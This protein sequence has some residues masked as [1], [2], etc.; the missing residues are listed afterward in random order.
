MLQRAPQKN[1]I[2]QQVP[3][4]I[5]RTVVQVC[6][7][8][9][10][11]AGLSTKPLRGAE[12]RRVAIPGSLTL[13]WRLGR[14]VA[15]AHQ[16]KSDPVQAVAQAGQGALLFSGAVLSGG[17]CGWMYDRCRP[18]RRLSLK[19]IHADRA[20]QSYC[21]LRCWPRAEEIGHS[22]QAKLWMCGVRHQRALSGVRLPQRGWAPIAACCCMWTFRMRIWWHG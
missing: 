2:P 18:A 4:H 20:L 17:P 6:T 3:Q 21:C 13:A 10:C 7:A 5:C 22:L 1:P 14:A 12:L 15:R 8:M 16:A 19:E 11:A 9:G